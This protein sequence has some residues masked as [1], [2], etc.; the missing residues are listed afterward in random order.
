MDELRRD[1]LVLHLKSQDM[2]WMFCSNNPLAPKIT[3]INLLHDFKVPKYMFEERKDPRAHLVQYNDYM[4]VLGH[5]M[6]QSVR[7]FPRPLR[8]VPKTGRRKNRYMSLPRGSVRSF[9]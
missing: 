2:D 5:Q 7:S 4:N 6:L 3:T 8:E 1:V 9:L